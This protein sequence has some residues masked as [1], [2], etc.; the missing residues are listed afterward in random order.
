[1]IDEEVLDEIRTAKKRDDR[2]SFVVEWKVEPD[3]ALYRNASRRE[4]HQRLSD[5]YVDVK[6]PVLEALERL[7]AEIE[8]LPA[9]SQAIVTTSAHNWERLATDGGPLH[10][11]SVQ[12]LPNVTFRSAAAARR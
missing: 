8:D 10:G 12:I 7:G 2:C 1:M 6:A 4:R 5:F 11:G 9:S 3:P